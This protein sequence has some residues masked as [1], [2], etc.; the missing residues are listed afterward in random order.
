MHVDVYSHDRPEPRLAGTLRPSFMGS[1]LAGASFEYDRGFL[2]DGYALS[3]ELPLRPGRIFTPESTTMFGA[4][5][6]AAP[7]EWGRRLIQAAH[8]RQ[9]RREGRPAR[10]LREFDF[11]I[12]V[13]DLTRMGALRFRDPG[14]GAWLSEDEAVA[15][16]HELPR[17]LQAARRYEQHEATDEDIAYLNGIATSP[18][19]ARPKANIVTDNGT[20]ALVKLPH[21]KDA[22]F[23][24][25]RWEAVALTLAEDAGIRTASF[26]LGVTD[27]RK[28]VLISERFDRDPAGYRIPYISAYTALGLGTHNTG[29]TLTYV[30]LAEAIADLTTDTR[31]DLHELYRRVALSV[32]IGNID[33]HWHNHG[34]LRMDGRWQ[35]SPAFDLN[36]SFST[37]VGSRR[38]SDD[39]DPDVRRLDD[40]IEVADV[41]ELTADEAG[42]L[43]AEVAAA[44]QP[45]RDVAHRLGVTAGE[46]DAMAPAFAD[47]QIRH[48]QEHSP[49]GSTT[50]DLQPPEPAPHTGMVWVPPHS[51]LGAPV[52]GH[53]RKRPRP[54]R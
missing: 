1:V 10:Q 2:R 27:G 6:D 46:I 17:I 29:A 18:G 53:W 40:L 28:A 20:L 51:R 49:G 23:D 19:G 45:W 42:R 43:V 54:R 48:A 36:P 41:F 12:G 21:S 44:V 35:L 50:I 39:A 33:D 37:T 25:E 14:T 4:F 7:D 22:D 31:A 5:Q 9:A 13:S 8:T 11:L 47:D 34:F 16:M 32:L 52:A 15:N 3:P 24:V 38:I 26:T 30:D